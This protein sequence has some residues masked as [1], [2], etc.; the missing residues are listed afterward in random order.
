MANDALALG[1]MR[2]AWQ[3]GI[4]IP[5]QL[6]LVG[7]DNIPECALVWPGL[8]TM[9]QPMRTLGQEACRSLF[10][11]DAESGSR[12]PIV[13]RMTLVARESSGPA[14]AGP[15]VPAQL[16]DE[17]LPYNAELTPLRAG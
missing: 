3:R 14:P 17:P 10:E 7:F 11:P 12:K 4:R 5:Q 13:H 16:K 6:S 2:V 1:L 8:T 15:V 9:A